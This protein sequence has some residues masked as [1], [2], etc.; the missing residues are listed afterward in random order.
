MRSA[1]VTESMTLP[2][3]GGGGRRLLS[4]ALRAGATEVLEAFVAG[5]PLPAQ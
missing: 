3:V 1:G 4:G 2:V 5:Q